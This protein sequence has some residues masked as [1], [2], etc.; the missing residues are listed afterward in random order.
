MR[1]DQTKVR[2]SLYNLLSN[3]CKFTTNGRISIAVRLLADRRIEFS[4][5]DT[6]VGMTPEQSAK[7]FEPFTQADASTSRKYGGTGLGLV[8]SRRF[9]QMMGGD[10]TVQSQTNKGSTFTL[11]LPLNVDVDPAKSVEG[12]SVESAF[13]IHLGNRSGDRRRTGGA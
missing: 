7:L 12:D 10:I 4:V 11:T 5:S 3:A 13:D 6:G 1:S 8:I 9:A 2:Q